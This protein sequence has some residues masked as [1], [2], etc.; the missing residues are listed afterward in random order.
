M[1]SR[2]K[3][4]AGVSCKSSERWEVPHRIKVRHRIKGA[5]IV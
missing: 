2:I 4:T 3:S 5:D 1:T